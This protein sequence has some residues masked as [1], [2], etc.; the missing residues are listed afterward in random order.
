LLNTYYLSN[1]NYFGLTIG[2]CAFLMIGMFHPIVIKSEYYFGK[3]IWWIFMLTGLAASILSTLIKNY[4]SSLILGVLGFSC[5]W[6]TFEI[7]KQ[8]VRVLKGQAKMNPK[9]KYEYQK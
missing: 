9:R 8:H 1:L 6:S 4:Y 3:K 5:F 7:F 2:L